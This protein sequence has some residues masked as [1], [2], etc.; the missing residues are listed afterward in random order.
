M[1]QSL[2]LVTHELATNAAKYGALAAPRGRISVSWEIADGALVL[3]WLETGGP[4]CVEPAGQGF[5]AK[6][7]KA[8]IENQLR[9][10]LSVEWNPAGVRWSF[11]V[12]LDESA[13]S[14]PPTAVHPI[15]RR[16]RKILLVEDESMVALMMADF[17]TEFGLA[18][19]GPFAKVAEA[20]QAARDNDLDAAV[21]DINLNGEMVYPLAD[22]LL[23]ANV[24]IVFVTG[25]TADS[26]DPRFAELAVLHK[27]VEKEPLRQMLMKLLEREAQPLRAI[28]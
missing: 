12:P 28:V 17:I 8:T 27:P 20:L 13:V 25:Y 19:V 10:S 5:G 1:A 7:M 21:L 14:R 2:A 26:I 15:H 4:K 18:V 16:G 22:A 6:M 9:G 11:S 3:R 23:A 24:P